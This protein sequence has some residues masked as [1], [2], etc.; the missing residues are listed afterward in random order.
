MLT[1]LLPSRAQKCR[2]IPTESPM[3]AVLK[4]SI[5]LI[6]SAAILCVSGNAF[7][8][9]RLTPNRTECAD[10]LQPE[11]VTQTHDWVMRFWGAVMEANR[12]N[13]IASPS[14]VVTGEVDR[15]CAEQPGLAVSDAGK[16]AFLR[17]QAHRQVIVYN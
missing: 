17:I 9:G 5:A 11:R 4:P 10:A 8:Y 12:G 1:D 13:A 16:Q 14:A 15:I 3:D 2:V 6:L 7:A